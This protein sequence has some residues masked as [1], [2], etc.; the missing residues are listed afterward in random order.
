MVFGGAAALL[1]ACA[2][3]SRVPLQPVR[4]A[5]AMRGEVRSDYDPSVIY[6]AATDSGRTLP[7]VN[8]RK[9]R[10]ALYRQAVRESLGAS[11]GTIIIRLDECQLYLVR[12]GG[13]AIRYG[14]GIGKD[15]YSWSGV[16]SVNHMKSWP[17]WTPT[18]AMINRVPELDEHRDGMPGGIDNPLGARALYIYKGGA[19]TL[20][21]I[22]GTSEWWTIGR[23]MS[24]GCIRMINQDVI[25]LAARV[26]AGAKILVA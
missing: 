16:G 11:P 7:A 12:E 23:A 3:S 18:A 20:Y 4:Q 6:A 15:G 17:L 21:R 26:S 14:I 9:L 24:S 13:L 2:K 22:H 8:F 5:E 25:H 19:D 1:A 10:P